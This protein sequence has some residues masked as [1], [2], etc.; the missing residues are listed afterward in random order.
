MRSRIAAGA[1]AGL[2]SG[3]VYGIVIQGMAMPMPMG[4]PEPMMEMVARVAR[5]DSLVVGWIVLLVTGVIAGA[6]F[7][8]ALGDRAARLGAGLA[9]GALFGVL[10][11]VVGGLLL[12][13]LVLGMSAFAPVTMAPMRSTS[14]A[15]LAVYVLS[16][17]VL[18]GAYAA[19]SG[20]GSGRSE[21]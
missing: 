3:L 10:L 20:R 1:L 2:V 21:A 17:V 11:W 9:W 12:M 6:V 18:G 7:G 5:S 19:L 13:P 8:A 14:L 15:N 16:G 4:D